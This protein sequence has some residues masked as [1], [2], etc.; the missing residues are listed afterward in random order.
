LPEIQKLLQVVARELSDAHAIGISADRKFEHAYA[1][2][3][4][5]C[6]VPLRAEGY[7]VPKGGSRHKRTIDSLPYTL[8]ERWK[9]AADYIERC[10]RQRG[11]TVY[12]EIGVVSS[13]DA[14]DLLSKAEQLRGEVVAWLSETHPE[15]VPPD[16]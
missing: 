15:L 12:E 6:T 8:G 14:D 10:S 3:L 9:G 2:A 7:Q 13:E 4:Q 16:A 11:L 5:L 1:A